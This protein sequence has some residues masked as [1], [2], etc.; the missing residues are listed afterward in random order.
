MD[1]QLARDFAD[2]LGHKDASRLKALLRRD[3]DFKAMTPGRFWESASADAVVDEIM[4]GAWFDAS[5]DI[6]EIVQVETAPVG[7]RQ[8]V[9]YQFVVTNPDGRF[10]VEQ[11]AYYTE[12]D[13]RIDWMRVL[14]SG[15]RPR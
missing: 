1:D 13:G 11:Q 10:V 5:D 3:I 8:R 14:C 7:Q 15:F 6:K 12:K 4:L 2:A 9:G